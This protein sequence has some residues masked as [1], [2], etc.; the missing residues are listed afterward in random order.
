MKH[1]FFLV[2]TLLLCSSFSNIWSQDTYRVKGDIN[3]DGKADVS[4]IIMAT[5]HYYEDIITEVPIDTI[6][7]NDT[8]FDTINVV[9]NDTVYLIRNIEEIQCQDTTI[10]RRTKIDLDWSFSPDNATY[11]KLTYSCD[12][13]NVHLNEKGGIERVDQYGDYT[14]TATS[15]D[16]LHTTKTIKIHVV[17]DWNK[18]VSYEKALEYPAESNTG[19]WRQAS[20]AYGKYYVQGYKG[21]ANITVTDIE[22]QQVIA[23]FKTGITDRNPD[24]PTTKFP[25][26]N[27]MSFGHKLEESDPMP[28]LYCSSQY[29]VRR[30]DHFDD[31]IC[32]CIYIFRFKMVGEALTMQWIQTIIFNTTLEI[33]IAI[34]TDNNLLYITNNNHWYWYN[35]PEVSDT[36]ND[37]YLD[38]YSEYVGY[39]DLPLPSTY[40]KHPSNTSWPQQ[41]SYYDGKI[42]SVSGTTANNSEHY[43]NVFDLSTCQFTHHIDLKAIG[44]KFPEEPESLLVLNNEFYISYHS[45]FIARLIF[46][47]EE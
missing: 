35:L 30:V 42:L 32:P 44:L 41:Q 11:Q 33:D 25:H 16:E 24:Y 10:F 19:A 39:C 9:I 7:I 23:N 22:N 27:T 17:P 12:D 43:L 1:L 46:S 29:P 4:D 8:I 34:D 36:Y 47:D 20:C 37:V 38:K 40:V 45:T 2:S 13:P 3:G 5:S 14:I 15:K 21:G 18:I 6:V 31:K 28:L 26:F